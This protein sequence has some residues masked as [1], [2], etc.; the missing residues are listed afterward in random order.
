MEEAVIG[1]AAS[2]ELGDEVESSGG[3]SCCPGL[4]SSVLME[5]WLT[6]YQVTE[7]QVTSELII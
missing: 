3:R 6:E 2:K 4:P 1:L 7:H 5:Q